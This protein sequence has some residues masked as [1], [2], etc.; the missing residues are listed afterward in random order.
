MINSIA[1]IF[2]NQ[3]ASAPVP[4]GLVDLNNSKRHVCTH[5]STNVVP[6]GTFYINLHTNELNTKQIQVAHEYHNSPFFS[7]FVI[8]TFLQAAV[9]GAGNRGSAEGK[10][11]VCTELSYSKNSLFFLLCSVRLSTLPGLSPP[12]FSLI[13]N[14]LSL[15]GLTLGAP[16]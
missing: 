6:C 4:D 13:T 7:R 5:A 10:C 11:L 3:S 15:P 14:E 12:P 2:S 1:F 8:A 16:L 9:Q